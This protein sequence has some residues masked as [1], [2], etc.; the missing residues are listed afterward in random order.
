MKAFVWQVRP[1]GVWRASIVA[2]KRAN[3]DVLYIQIQKR[4]W[5]RVELEEWLQ[6]MDIQL[7]NQP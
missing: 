2:P 1:Y 6:S 5:S 4:S 3:N 7:V